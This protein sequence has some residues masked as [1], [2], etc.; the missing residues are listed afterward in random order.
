MANTFDYSIDTTFLLIWLESQVTF[1]FKHYKWKCSHQHSDN[2]SNR[3]YK[4]I[5]QL[6][7]YP[8]WSIILYNLSLFQLVF[9]ILLLL[10]SD[11]II[12]FYHFLINRWNYKQI[13]FYQHFLLLKSVFFWLIYSVWDLLNINWCLSKRSDLNLYSVGFLIVDSF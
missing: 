1:Y 4:I 7:V 13:D 2:T 3:K 12:S 5:H 10:L 11:R 8:E 9:H 6:M